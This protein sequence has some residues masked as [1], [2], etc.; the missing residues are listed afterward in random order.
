MYLKLL[1]TVTILVF[2]FTSTALAFAQNDDKIVVF[3]TEFGH[4]AIELFS[5]DAPNTVENFLKLAESDFY[6]KT[7]FHRIING[8][9]IQGGDP[10]SKESDQSKWGQGGTGDNLKAE[11]NNIK[12]DRGIVSMARSAHPDSASSQ[13]FIVH[14]RHVKTLDEKYT[15][16]GRI[17]TQESYDTLDKIADLE[18]KAGNIPLEVEKA[19]IKKTEVVTRSSLENIL[20]LDAPERG[21]RVIIEE[22]IA[23]E[24]IDGLT[25]TSG[26]GKY[27]NTE[28]GF[29]FV[30]QEGWMFQR[31]TGPDDPVLVALGVGK[32]GITPY[33]S[34]Q[35]V[36]TN[37]ESFEEI[38]APLLESYR[39][40]DYGVGGGILSEEYYTG[41][42][43][44]AGKHGIVLVATQTNHQLPDT[45]DNVTQ[46]VTIKFK[47]V[48]L[49]A[50]H[51]HFIITYLNNEN[52]FDEGLV[53]FDNMV[54]SFK[55][56]MPSSQKF[57]T[58]ESEVIVLD[59]ESFNETEKSGCLIA[60]AAFGSEMAP[61]VQ[62]LREIRDNIV[63]Q[64]ES[65]T[66][67]MAG[68]NQFYYSF[69]PTIAD[70]EREN[71]VF[72]E[73][74]KL[75]ITPLLASLTLLQFADIDSESEMLGY[76]IGVILLNVGIYFVIPAVFIM[77]I[78]KLQ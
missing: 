67:F 64:T 34:F 16:F 44:I 13:F 60:T 17:I 41:E 26:N 23:P 52:N 12:H 62:F 58:P 24:Y 9:M 32:D 72:K 74:V 8:F 30:T 77:K 50:V 2:C 19:E 22:V 46:Y 6:D 73:S 14:D 54:N 11:F 42:N 51:F 18:T 35:A 37:E 45:P 15:V 31:G 78:R 43:R 25:G 10:N 49:E 61:Q 39:E 71:P 4:L 48:I 56:S 33:I 1:T 59:D 68:F 20:T 7:I 29:S 27:R 3:H 5:D 57:T 38:F 28:Y 40:L 36:E 63:L 66:S 76:G 69:S 75:A 65:G 55:T 21:E 53:D 70:Y 47:Q